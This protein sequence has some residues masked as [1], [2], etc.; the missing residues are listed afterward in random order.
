MCFFQQKHV[1]ALTE[2]KIQQTAFQKEELFS[3]RT[4]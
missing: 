4:F 3:S 1:L 2:S